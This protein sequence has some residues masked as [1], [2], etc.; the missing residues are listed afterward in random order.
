VICW[1][2]CH[3]KMDQLGPHRVLGVW[4]DKPAP[5]FQTAL[6]SVVVAS[7]QQIWILQLTFLSSPFGH[8]NDKRNGWRLSWQEIKA[9][10]NKEL[11]TLLND[12]QLKVMQGPIDWIFWWQ[13]MRHRNCKDLEPKWHEPCRDC[14][15][16][17]WG[18]WINCSASA[19]PLYAHSL[20]LNL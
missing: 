8:F 6:G 4:V 12:R 5:I 17:R 11:Q 18:R 2:T 9:Q 19:T 13:N 7:L 3:P 16:C 15:G 10:Q 20:K 14:W 1:Y